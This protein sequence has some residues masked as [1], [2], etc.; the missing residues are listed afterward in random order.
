MDCRLL[1][2]S[3]HAILQARILE[4][5]A[6]SF[7]CFLGTVPLFCLIFLPFPRHTVNTVSGSRLHFTAAAVIVVCLINDCDGGGNL[8]EVES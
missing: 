5:V 7:S 3:V 4:W 1:G 8:W 2:S 6:I